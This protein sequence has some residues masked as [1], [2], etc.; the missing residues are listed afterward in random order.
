MDAF[1]SNFNKNIRLVKRN[2][3][4]LLFDE[5]DK[6]LSTKDKQVIA[7]KLDMLESLMLEFLHIGKTSFVQNSIE[8]FIAENLNMDIESVLSDMD[9]ERYCRK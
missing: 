7:D 1:K 6:D 3:K 8:S 2:E 5:I 9:F 4:G